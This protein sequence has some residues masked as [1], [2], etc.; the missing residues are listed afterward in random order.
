[1]REVKEELDAAEQARKIETESRKKDP[2]G[3]I[4]GELVELIE[5]WKGASR[6][7]AEELFGKVRDRVN[8]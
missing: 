3:E 8:K 5:K 2:E 4:D 7:A 6:Q 1:L